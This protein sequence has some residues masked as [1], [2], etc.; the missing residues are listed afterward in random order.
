MGRASKYTDELRERLELKVTKKNKPRSKES[1]SSTVANALREA[2]MQGELQADNRIK[3]YAVG[4]QFGVSRSPV[5]EA[6]NLLA[7][8]GFIELEKDVGARV[9]PLDIQELEELYLAREAIEPQMI[10]LACQRISPEQLS[11]AVALNEEGERFAADDDLVRYLQVD[12]EFHRMLLEAS[13][14]KSLNEITALLWQRTQRYRLEYTAGT[15]LGT[16]VRE[17]RMILDAFAGH[18]SDDAADLYR[19]HT[20]RTR[21]TLTHRDDPL[22]AAV[23]KIE[24][25]GTKQ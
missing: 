7:F 17:H 12:R 1:M 16:S 8:E 19:I 22:I 23:T 21:L 14:L 15:H 24:D 5:R 9:K 4:Q 25:E 3:Q 18:Q 13:G 20:R 6:F 2:I 10:S 11:A